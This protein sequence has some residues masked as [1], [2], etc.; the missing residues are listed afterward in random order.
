MANGTRP[1]NSFSSLTRRRTSGICP[2]NTLSAAGYRVVSA[3]SGSEALALLREEP[4]DLIVTDLSLKGLSG[5]DVAKAAREIRADI[6]VVLISG[7]ANEGSGSATRENG[8]DCYLKKPFT[9]KDFKK[10]IQ[11][12]LY[13]EK[14]SVTL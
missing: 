10:A 7:W 6:R 11:N 2:T 12:L 13:S 3:P 8:I 9:L 14:P 5:L 1:R 4:V